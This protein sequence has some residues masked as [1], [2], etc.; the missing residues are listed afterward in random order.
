MRIVSTGRLPAVDREPLR[1]G[2]QSD[3]VTISVAKAANRSGL[4][5]STIRRLCYTG[6][7]RSTRVGA[8]RLVSVASLNNLLDAG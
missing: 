1:G 6:K 7:L 5:E 2:G 8:R 4:G 3:E